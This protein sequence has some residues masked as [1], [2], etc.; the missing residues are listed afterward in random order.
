M[1]YYEHHLGDYA[2]ATA[3]LSFVEDAAY[4]RCIRKYYATEMPLAA[5]TKTVQRL[6]GARSKEERE[7]VETVLSEFFTLEADGWHN[8]RCDE[9]I[10]RFKDKQAKAKRS[11]DARWNPKP[12]DTEGNANASETHTERIADAMPDGCEGNALQSPD[13]SLQTPVKKSSLRS[14]SARAREPDPGPGIVFDHWKA[15][16][17]HP[18]AHFDVK[19]RKRIEARLKDFTPEQLCDAISG[20]RNSPWHRGTD[21][22][23]GGTVYDSLDTLL[24]D[25]AQVETGLRLLAH[26][27]QPPRPPETPG[28]ALRRAVNG[29]HDESRVIEYDPEFRQLARG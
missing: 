8:Q 4:S 25:T 24:R 18:G 3:H 22:K 1:N 14:D 27:P 29:G 11:A 19:R 6:I 23:G 12:P 21:P 26:P 2:E 10:A 15:T 20:F 13:T 7:A 9:E 16:W 5:D 28:D 17:G